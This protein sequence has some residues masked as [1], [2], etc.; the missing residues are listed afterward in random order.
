MVQVGAHL[1]HGL[2]FAG[3][4]ALFALGGLWL[5]RRVGTEPVFVI[6]GALVGATAGFLSM[7]WRLVIEPRKR[8]GG[9]RQERRERRERGGEPRG[10]AR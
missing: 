5:D 7:Y 8:A 6:V 2:T 4:T 3:A 9:E 1:T 10:G